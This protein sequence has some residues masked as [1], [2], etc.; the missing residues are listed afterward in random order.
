[1][2]A[3]VRRGSQATPIPLGITKFDLPI[4]VWYVGAREW[5]VTPRAAPPVG[6]CPEHFSVCLAS[7]RRKILTPP[8]LGMP[9]AGL[10]LQGFQGSLLNLITSSGPV[11]TL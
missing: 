2:L 7:L 3:S 6:A 8:C 4:S 9:A 5:K 11:A 10:V 1:M